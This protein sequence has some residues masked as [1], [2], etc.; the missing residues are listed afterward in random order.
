MFYVAILYILI[1]IVSAIALFWI[2][3]TLT[4][5]HWKQLGVF[6]RKPFPFIGNMGL[7]LLMKQSVHEMYDQL[8]RLID[9]LP[10]GGF[11]E[12][13]SPVLILKDPEII[14]RVLITDFKYF[15]D[16]GF[17]FTNVNKQLNPLNEHLFH[18]TGQRWKVLRQKMS[19]VFTSGKLKGMQNQISDCVSMFIDNVE[20]GMTDD[21][22][23]IDLKDVFPQLTVD[24]TGSCAFGI[25][26]NA[27]KL[28]NDF[29]MFAH[30]VLKPRVS[31]LVKYFLQV[32]DKRL[33]HLFQLTDFP[34]YYIKFFQNVV[35]D[36][37]LHRRQ[38]NMQRC[39][40]LQQLMDMQNAAVDS[41][42]SKDVGEKSLSKDSKSSLSNQVTLFE[43]KQKH[44]L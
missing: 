5:N 4:F 38:N 44:I 9:K 36:A 1:I 13:R 24:V 23:D 39:D 21:G 32:I 43:W 12:M 14:R 37:V 33:P 25:E 10:Y 29:R 26:C 22:K 20:M 34:S 2:F 28:K 19:P 30:E 42:F 27:I 31:L 41:K 3:S 40:L 7:L 16:R 15:I 18:Y 17:S 8:Y 11:F 35:Y 6:Y